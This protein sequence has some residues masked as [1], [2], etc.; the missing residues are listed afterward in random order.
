ML[1]L[2]NGESIRSANTALGWRP[3]FVFSMGRWLDRRCWVS[4]DPAE[5]KVRP[6]RRVKRP[7]EIWMRGLK[8]AQFVPKRK[9]WA[10]PYDAEAL[11][12]GMVGYLVGEVIADY[13]GEPR[14]RRHVR[15]YL[16]QDPGMFMDPKDE[17]FRAVAGEGCLLV[18]HR[19]VAF[20]AGRRRG[21]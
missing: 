2:A 12:A 9:G 18:I 1:P 6:K 10:I 21:R 16:D 13:S 20:P 17:V 3:H 11:A 8:V 14:E 4:H 5:R 19:W 7:L 15:V